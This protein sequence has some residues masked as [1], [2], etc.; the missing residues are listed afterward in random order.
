MLAH[1]GVRMGVEVVADLRAFVDDNMRMQNRIPPDRNVL[2]NHGKGADGGPFADLSSGRD[3]C[4]RMMPGA[5][6]GGW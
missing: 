1:H 3:G 2:A 4:L 6:R 5:G